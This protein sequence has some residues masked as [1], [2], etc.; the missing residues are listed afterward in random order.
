[1]SPERIKA[2][3]ELRR[4]QVVDAAKLTPEERFAKVEQLRRFADAAGGVRPSRTDESVEF[5]VA[6]RR[7]RLERYGAATT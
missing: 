1:M 7:R 4:R 2:L 6:A 3:E 5:Q